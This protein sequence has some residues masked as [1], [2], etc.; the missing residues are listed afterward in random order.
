MSVSHSEWLHS[1]YKSCI[2]VK[3]FD[4]DFTGSG[5][6]GAAQ[7]GDMANG[8]VDMQHMTAVE[9][10]HAQRTFMIMTNGGRR[11]RDAFI[12]VL[13]QDTT[14]TAN[15]PTHSLTRSRRAYVRRHSADACSLLWPPRS[16]RA[17]RANQKIPTVRSR[18][19]FRRI[20]PDGIILAIHYCL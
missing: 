1:V 15:A 7:S 2:C 17:H 4:D 14:P 6:M 18:Y 9:R 5:L 13:L 3:L 10:Q 20:A 8:R 12:I 16:V 19:D 11:V